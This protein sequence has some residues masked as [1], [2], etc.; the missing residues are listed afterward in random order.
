MFQD[1]PL[2]PLAQTC[3]T[4]HCQQVIRAK[5]LLTSALT[6]TPIAHIPKLNISPTANSSYSKIARRQNTYAC[7]LKPKLPPTCIDWPR[8]ALSTDASRE[9][10]HTQIEV[11]RLPN[12]MKT[13]F[14]YYHFTRLCPNKR[15]CAWFMLKLTLL[16]CLSHHA[17][18]HAWM[19]ISPRDLQRASENIVLP[20]M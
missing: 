16:I 15:L 2:P 6:K 14:A 12:R 8:H 9:A 5:H 19:W 3:L 10:P 13:F 11:S 18:R 20:P 7:V 17:V 4:T 1:L